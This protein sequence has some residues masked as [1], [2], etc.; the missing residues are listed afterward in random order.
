MSLNWCVVTGHGNDYTEIAFRWTPKVWVTSSGGITYTATIHGA[1]QGQE[2]D[3]CNWYV[4]TNVPDNAVYEWRIGSEFLSNSID[5][6]RVLS[7]GSFTL[8]VQVWN[9]S[10]GAGASAFHE[11]GV[12]GSFPHCA[13]E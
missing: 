2:G 1:T 7:N 3:T 6:I 11:V 8:E 13:V 10:T 9:P 4:E 12:S 5:V